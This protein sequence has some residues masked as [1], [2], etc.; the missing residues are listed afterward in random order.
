MQGR[1][2]KRGRIKIKERERVFYRTHS[3][4]PYL[5]VAMGGAAVTQQADSCTMRLLLPVA[6]HEGFGQ[7]WTPNKGTWSERSSRLPF[8][9]SESDVT[10][11]QHL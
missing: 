1:R 10:K 3:F 9:S 5:V 2:E 6:G 11:W 4:T 8:V 7:F